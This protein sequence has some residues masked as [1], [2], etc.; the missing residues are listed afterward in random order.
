MILANTEA[1]LGVTPGGGG[2]KD[3]RYQHSDLARWR[4]GRQ[5]TVYSL[6]K[7]GVEGK[8]R[9]GKTGLRLCTGKGMRIEEG[10][11]RQNSCCLG[12]MGLRQFSGSRHGK[13]FD[14]R[15]QSTPV[16]V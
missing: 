6:A 10:K 9:E 5:K 1:G 12:G 8:A 13:S 16:E 15:L 3:I 4:D 2:E 14:R 7:A 11:L